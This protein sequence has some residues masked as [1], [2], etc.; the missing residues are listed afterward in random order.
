[1][2]LLNTLLCLSIIILCASS[3]E[4]EPVEYTETKDLHQYEYS[5]L[6]QVKQHDKLSMIK[7]GH[8][9]LDNETHLFNLDEGFRWL[10]KAAMIEPNF[11]Q[12]KTI[13]QILYQHPNKERQHYWLIHGAK[14]NDKEAIDMLFNF[15]N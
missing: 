5:L 14:F 12:D 4:V 13:I 11:A 2:K 9:Y 7:L 1:M 10:D 8:L 15:S 6:E 3:W